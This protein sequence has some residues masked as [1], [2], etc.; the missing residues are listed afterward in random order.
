MPPYNEVNNSKRFIP[1]I[2]KLDPTQEALRNPYMGTVA[3]VYDFMI[4]DLKKAKNFLPDTNKR[5]RANKY[6]A[7]AF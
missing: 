2:T 4:S 3:E 6:A 7:S 5:G 1:L